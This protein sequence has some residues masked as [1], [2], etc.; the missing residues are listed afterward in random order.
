[1]GNLQTVQGL[2]MWVSNG[3]IFLASEQEPNRARRHQNELSASED[4]NHFLENGVLPRS[5][6][7]WS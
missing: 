2:K 1:M 5:K 7:N 6:E 3:S 4:I